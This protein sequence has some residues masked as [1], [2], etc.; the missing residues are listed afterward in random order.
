MAYGAG[1]FPVAP[2]VVAQGV[3]DHGSGKR[4]CIFIQ[5]ADGLG[6]SPRWAEKDRVD[7]FD[8]SDGPAPPDIFALDKGQN[9]KPPTRLLY[10]RDRRCAI[11]V[12]WRC[13]PLMPAGR[14]EQHLI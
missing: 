2:S 6:I 5:I 12:S 7:G 4:R 11:D 9:L 10:R 14:K 3:R 1:F 8:C 13:P